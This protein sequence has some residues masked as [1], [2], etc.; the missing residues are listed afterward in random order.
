MFHLTIDTP[1]TWNYSKPLEESERYLSHFETVFK[2]ITSRLTQLACSRDP[3]LR[4]VKSQASHMSITIGMMEVKVTKILTN[5][6][7]EEDIDEIEWYHEEYN[8]LIYDLTQFH[9]Q[10]NEMIY[11]YNKCV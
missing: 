10:L 1:D 9:H 5:L 3:S 8:K 4:E 7:Y 6:K 11:Q 2:N